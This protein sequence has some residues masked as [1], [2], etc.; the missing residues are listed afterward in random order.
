M[1]IKT[2]PSMVQARILSFLVH[3]RQRFCRKDLIKL[4][5]SMLNEGQG[6]DFW[7]KKTAQQL[8]DVLSASDFE[9]VSNLNLDS[10]EEIAED[11]FTTLPDWLKDAAKTGD[12]VLP[13]LPISPD[14]FNLRMPFD[15]LGEDE[16]STYIAEEDKE[17]HVDEIM[18]E[19]E[20]DTDL[21]DV[22]QDPEFGKMVGSLK[23][24]ILNLE[25]FSK[26]AEVANE[27]H[28]LYVRSRVD[29]LAVL[30]SIE[31]WKADDETASILISHLSDG[32]EDELGWP[33]QVLCAIVLPKML[34]LRVPASRVL[35]T[36]II[37]YCKV[38]Q[39]AA[40]Y[41]LLF[42]LILK[43][44]GINNP[45][46]DVITRIIRECLHPAHVSAFCQKFLCKEVN[47][48]KFICLPCHRSLIGIELEWTES[49]FTL[50]QNILNHNVHLTQDTVDQLVHGV[51]KVTHT[52]SRSLKLCNFV[53]CLVNKCSPFLKSHKLLLIQSVEKTNTLVTKSILSKLASL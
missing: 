47:A 5:Q 20:E 40:E 9:W 14:E 29:S 52:F 8:L 2:L 35:L 1:Y 33:S 25:T 38:H 23:L 21:K 42:P 39:K 11:K 4:A 18:K 27:I 43:V 48:E 7:V 22:S 51:C 6:L 13:W 32:N 24:R 45:I 3:D 15:S 16:D 34:H 31:P 44:E 30:N 50:M 41:A 49:F 26:T 17:G 37:E 53:L 46:C 28:Q 10:E 12:L 36:A 19:V